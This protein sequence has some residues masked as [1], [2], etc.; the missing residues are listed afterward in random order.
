MRC[1]FCDAVL[2]DYE[3]TKHVRACQR[4]A[5]G[6]IRPEPRVI[7]EEEREATERHFRGWR[8]LNRGG[9]WL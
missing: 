9:Q 8:G 5:R 1:G 2:K 7:T 3:H 4:I 6:V